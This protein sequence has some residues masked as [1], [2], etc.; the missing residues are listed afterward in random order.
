M[1]NF[2]LICCL[3]LFSTIVK[4][5][6]S[7]ESKVY[8]ITCAVGDEIYE[9]FGHSAIRIEDPINGIDNCYNWGMF[10]YGVDD[11]TFSMNFIKGTVT[12]YMAV[13]PFKMFLGPY[14][15]FHREVIQQELNLTLEVKNQLWALLAENAKPENM[16]Y[17]YDFFF[18]NCATRI[19][20]FLEQ[21][22]GDKL[23]IKDIPEL[24]SQTY[25]N[26]VD[27]G[28]A[29]FP[30]AGFGVDLVLGYKVDAELGVDGV[31]YSP[32]LMSQIY[33][34][35]QISTP[36]GVQNLVI[37]KDVVVA[38]IIRDESHDVIFTPLVASIVILV[39]TILLSFFKLNVIF[40]VWSSLLF[41]VIG[42]VGCVMLV[43]WFGAEHQGTK[44][45]FN[46]I[47][48]NPLLFV[49]AVMIWIKKI[50]NKIGKTYLVIAFILFGMILFFMMLP[51]EFPA[52]ARVIIINLALQ[53]YV[54]HKMQLKELE[55]VER[56]NS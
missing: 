50:N 3:V 4:A 40:K 35:S 34:V 47:W 27:K 46:V 20:D 17:K 13:E 2:F 44:G 8:L 12:Y 52:P 29:N 49:L 16:Y 36:S 5:Q 25:R 15:Y 43:M 6:L 21:L 31:M 14:K 51:Q 33:D 42:V 19:D 53:F 56:L 10:E 1:K 38:G 24:T 41:V 48:A 39:I 23:I 45:N 54:L 30:W 11:F 22:L 37:S 28:F 7:E 32:I 18:D 9:Q 26:D 55:K